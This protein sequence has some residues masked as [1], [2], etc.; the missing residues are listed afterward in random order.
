MHFSQ[1]VAEYDFLDLGVDGADQAE[2]QPRNYEEED[3]SLATKIQRIFTQLFENDDEEAAP[4]GFTD[5][6]ALDVSRHELA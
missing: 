3:E 2:R 1:E 4:V 5:H 6:L